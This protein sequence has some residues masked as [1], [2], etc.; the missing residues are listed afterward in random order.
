MMTSH[1]N[2]TR[3]FHARQYHIHSP[4]EICVHATENYHFQVGD[5]NCIA[6]SDCIGSMPGQCIV[7]DTP[8][9]R[10]STVFAE[11]GL[12]LTETIFHYN[13]LYLQA[14]RQRILIDAGLGRAAPRDSA[15]LDRL[16]AAGMPRNAIPKLEGVL[17]DR[18]QAEGLTPADIDRVI[19]THCD[20]DHI[21]GLIFGGER[22]FPNADYIFLKDAWDFWSDAARVAQWPEFLMAI[23]CR[24]LPLIQDRLQIVEAGVEFL[25]GFQLMLVPG[26][27]PGH[28]AVAITSAGQHLIHVADTIGHPILMEYPRWHGFADFV[29]EQ[30]AQDRVRL[31]S[32]AVEQQ[33]LVFGSHLPFPGVGHVVPQGEGWRWQPLIEGSS[34]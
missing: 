23:G 9:D 26:H 5:L 30:A 27:R 19:I 16:E 2:S 29:H 6:M 22:V 13:C 1:T 34:I 25:P 11:Y 33:A 24:T 20:G 28:T 3:Y 12:S 10:V 7:K 31:L 4:K 15:A 32:V 18:L 17:L 14:D 8:A 21:G